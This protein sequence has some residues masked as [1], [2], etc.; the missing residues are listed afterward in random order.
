MKRFAITLCL[1]CAAEGVA[2]AQ[3]GSLQAAPPRDRTPAPVR[4]GTASI[5]GRVVD[6]QTGVPIARAHVRVIPAPDPSNALVTTDDSGTFAFRSLAAGSYM[7]DAEKAPYLAARYPEAGKTVRGMTKRLTLGDGESL[8][9]IT[10]PMSRGS[11]IAGRVLDANGEALEFANVQLLALPPSGHGRPMQ[12]GGAGTNDLG[13]FRMAHLDAGKYLVLVVPRNNGVPDLGVPGDVVAAQP[14][15]TF[16]PGVASVDQAQPITIRRG[17]SVTGLEITIVESFA[18]VVSG[19]IVDAS[20]QPV[21]CCGGISVRPIV[22]DM[23]LFGGSG[24]AIRP[25]GTFRVRLAPGEYELSVNLVPRGV[26][27]PPPPGS[28][29]L[30]RTQI[31]VGADLS[32]VTIVVGGGAKVSGR[33]VLDGAGTP[34][35]VPANPNINLV[36]LASPQD[37]RMCRAG[38]LELTPELTFTIDGVFGT[39][40]PRASGNV[41]GW[42]VK[43]IQYRGKE[44]LDLPVAFEPGQQ[45]RDVRVVLSDK[46][47]ELALRVTDD[48]GAPTRDFVALVFSAD[49]TRWT[50]GSSSVRM[51]F[52]PPASPRATATADAPRPLTMNNL[53][54]GDYFAIAIDDIASDGWQDPG[55]LEKIAYAATHVSLADGSPAEVSLR[56]LKLADLVPDR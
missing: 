46:H 21:A 5:Q 4:T 48:G 26:G 8:P 53:P 23:P 33:V 9:S 51:T 2:W 36:S 25:D 49:R 40:I 29:R 15:P 38:R 24:A 35:A 22:N 31:S 18:A 32:N 56:R 27:G 6:S 1:L 10:I 12:R 13:E 11:V 39:C 34:P 28:E 50:E 17:E 30:G 47:T 20:G 42:T 52:P 54:A 41:G 19:T 55:L 14:L 7:L 45:L 37:G 44:M 16:F 3:V 43:S